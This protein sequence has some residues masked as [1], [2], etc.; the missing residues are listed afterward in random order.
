MKYVL[1]KRSYIFLLTV[2]DFIGYII[3]LPLRIIRRGFP[4]NIANILVIRLD[5]I[6]DVIFSTTVLE[7]LQ[8]HYVGA[9]ITFL[10]ASWAKNIVIDNPYIDEVI[11]Y[12]APWFD[13]N[14]RKVFEFKKFFKLARELQRHNYDLGI[15]LR[16]D[17]RHLL[18]MALAGVRFKVGYSIT[19]GDFLLD[20]RVEYKDGAHSV[21]HN[22]DL[23][24]DL[25]VDIVTDRPQIY[26]C[27]EDKR[28]T[29]EFFKENN[30]ASDDFIVAI[31]PYAGYPSKNW[32]DSRFADLIEILDE[33]YKAKIILVGGEKDKDKV[34]AIL[35]MCKAP[36]ISACG[37]TSLGELL[38]LI[39]RSSVFI[40]VDSGPSHIAATTDTPILVLYSGTNISKE[41][42]PRSEK[43]VIIQKDIP[44]KGCEKLDCEHNICMDLISVED[45]LDEVEQLIRQPLGEKA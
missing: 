41:W 31:H 37:T 33:K 13:Q 16:G 43:T 29:E 15:D 45:V 3:S 19:G 5:H 30:L 32:L 9:K 12:D 24:R 20:K 8:K 23:L 4:G 26:S 27:E 17:F 40:G 21:Q 36:V 38:E 10:V 42:G 2:I 1:K 34:K 11:C 14:K 6:G 22:L 7:N 44:C 35:G 18:L 39:K 25:K 28:S